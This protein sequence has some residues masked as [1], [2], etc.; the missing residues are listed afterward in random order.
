MVELLYGLSTLLKKKA[1]HIV[2]IKV[3]QNYGLEWHQSS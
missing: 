2:E 1:S 3:S